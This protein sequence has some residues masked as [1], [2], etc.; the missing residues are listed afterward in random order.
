MRYGSIS[1]VISVIV[2]VTLPH[3]AAAQ[4]IEWKELMRQYGSGYK[5]PDPNAPPPPPPISEC[6]Q[7][8]GGAQLSGLVTNISWIG[9]PEL[10]A[11]V[12]INERMWHRIDFQTKRG[13]LIAARCG[14]GDEEHPPYRVEFRSNLTDR[15]LGRATGCTEPKC[16][17]DLVVE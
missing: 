8:W 13:L 7:A 16:D 2:A 4:K 14:L 9:L 6:K 3:D 10:P 11:T 1:A 15:V 17:W 12:T 5:P